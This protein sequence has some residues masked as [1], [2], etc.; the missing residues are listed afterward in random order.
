MPKGKPGVTLATKCSHTDRPN[1]S[2]GLCKTCDNRERYRIEHNTT[3]QTPARK[4]WLCEHS[5]QPAIKGYCRR[6]YSRNSYRDKHP[7]AFRYDTPALDRF[8]ARVIEQPNGCWLWSGA[9]KRSKD[10]SYPL[11]TPPLERSPRH[12]VAWAYS[13]IRGL[14]A[15]KRDDGVELSHTCTTGSPCCNPYHVVEETHTAN[16]RRSLPAMRRTAANARTHIKPRPT[17]THCRRGHPRTPDNLYS[18]NQCKAC[19]AMA[20]KGRRA[21]NAWVKAVEKAISAQDPQENHNSASLS[22][23]LDSGEAA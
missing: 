20:G 13:N 4:S 16:M 11:F 1:A 19:H 7:D 23:I 10:G 9:R 21:L 8:M 3:G 12:A 5:D 2:R 15:P 17:K 6:C 22:P 18:N 14:K